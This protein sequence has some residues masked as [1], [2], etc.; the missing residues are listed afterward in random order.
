MA[1]ATARAISGAA[2]TWVFEGVFMGGSFRF[3]VRLVGCYRYQYSVAL[4]T[5]NLIMHRDA[6]LQ[7]GLSRGL[8]VRPVLHANVAEPGV[9]ERGVV[10]LHPDPDVEAAQ[11]VR[12]GG[13]LFSSEAGILAKVDGIPGAGAASDKQHLGVAHRVA[14]L[15]VVV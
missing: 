2:R 1:C 3:G 12:L 15:G 13:A 5:C 7:A 9:C 14:V 10:A 4:D 6:R 8:E 11:W